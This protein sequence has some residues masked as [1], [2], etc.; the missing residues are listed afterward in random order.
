[1]IVSHEMIG[2]ML[3][4]TL[5]DEPPSVALTRRQPHDV[6][7]AVVGDHCHPLRR[8]ESDHRV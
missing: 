1:L 3:L 8:D 7:N 6:I 2:R 4:R 5:L